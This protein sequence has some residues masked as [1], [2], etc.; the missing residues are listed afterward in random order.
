MQQPT[1]N[2]VRGVACLGEPLVLTSDA[3]PHLAGAQ[4]G[5]HLAGAQAGLH[6]AG[7]EANVAA[8][9]V[10]WGLPAA[11][12][13]RLGDDDFGALIRS[14]LIA[15]G[16]DV[17]AVEIDPTRPTGHYSK[18][19]APDETGEPQTV[20]RYTRS[21]S[22]ASAMTPA[23]LDSPALAAAFAHASVVHCSGITAALSDTCLAMMR[24]LLTDRPGITGRMSF[25]VN[26]REQLWPDG[27]PAK[28]VDLANR[29]DLVLVGADEALRVMGTADPAELRRILPAPA[30]LVIKD[31]ARRAIAVDRAGATIIVPALNVEVV[32]PVGAGDAFAAGFLAGVVRGEDT[33]T[34]LR[35]GHLGAAVTL[36]VVA[37]SAPPPPDDL[38]R[39][40]LTC[41]EQQWAATTVT[42]SGISMQD[43]V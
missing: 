36:T 40:L 22:A 4:A 16:V 35:R 31:G 17:S 28:V 19:T 12:V 37:D 7:A 23:F 25:D 30:T 34:C 15:R 38:A 39:Q 13:G 20:S 1:T 3:D 2:P 27:D 5:L 29:A 26:W 41:S 8:G 32:E 33:A 6:L 21:G 14:E 24:R 43:G 42:A 10:A 11:F 9:L 18:V